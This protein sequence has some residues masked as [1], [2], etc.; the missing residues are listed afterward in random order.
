MR[1]FL[2]V[3]AGE[4]QRPLIECAAQDYQVVVAAPV[5]P[6]EFRQYVS[7]VVLCDVRDK[8][9]ILRF[10]QE[11]DI[12]GVM[13]DQTDI[14]VR[15][16]AYV[17]ER[18]GLPGI[19]SETGELFTD[20][21]LMKKR[22]T[23]LGI[24]MLAHIVTS[25]EAE[26]ISFYRSLGKPV[27]LKPLDTQ[28]SRGVFAC[29]DEDAIRN[30]FAESAGWSSDGQVIV[31]QYIENGR[32]FYIEG[33][34]FD[35]QF[36]NLIIGDSDPFDIPDA[37]AARTRIS[38]STAPSELVSKVLELNKRIITGFGLKQGITESEF[39]SDGVDAYLLEAAAR[40]G[41]TYCSSDQIPLRTG[42]Q[43][44]R[45]LV[46]IATGKLSEAPVPHETGIVCGYL[47]F[48]LPVGTV[49]EIR[50]REEVQGLPYVH[51]N[52]LSS[53]HEGLVIDK[54]PEDKTSRFAI[55]VSAQSREELLERME[56]I[57]KVLE[58]TVATPEGGHAG[59]IW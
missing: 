24:P 13:T 55:T 35:Y 17:A 15:T 31:E 2:V 21:A 27:I 37:F 8:E 26:A 50:G 30:H 19:G 48:Y 41:G 57:K 47:A 33:M 3:G 51:R 40:G 52:Q 22:M 11:H 44:E 38:P 54:G 34:A 46:D 49:V 6:D 29:L 43:P 12:C 4:F 32:E 16:V 18:M 36:T 56:G 1:N 14:A 9:T 25:D 5:V 23:E 53:I 58:V 10:A 20:K 45:F 7:D 42:V 59:I 39:I 28:G